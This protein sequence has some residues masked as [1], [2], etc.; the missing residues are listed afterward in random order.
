MIYKR[1]MQ[2]VI[3]SNEFK[4]DVKNRSV[5]DGYSYKYPYLLLNKNA[6]CDNRIHKIFKI[7]VTV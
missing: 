1:D 5:V 4:V 2:K 3:E 7:F 6:I